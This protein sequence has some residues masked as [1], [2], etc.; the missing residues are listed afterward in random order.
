MSFNSQR[1]YRRAFGIFSL[2]CVFSY[3]LFHFNNYILFDGEISKYAGYYDTLEYIRYAIT[4]LVFFLIPTVSAVILTP[5]TFA[6]KA[7]AV[8]PTALLLSA[9]YVFYNIPYYYMYHIAY[10]YDSIESLLICIP[11]SFILSLIYALYTLGLA[12]LARLIF[13]RRSDTPD[14]AKSCGHFS[15]SSSVGASVFSSVAIH[16]AFSF[17][18]ELIDA[19]SFFIEYADSYRIGELIYIVGRFIFIMLLMLLCQAVCIT[20]HNKI[21]AKRFSNDSVNPNVTKE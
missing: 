1:L 20:V 15:L 4:D 7:Y 2:L 13:Y 11:Y 18:R 17:I 10:G 19:V 21:L 9:S 14:Y 12:Y 6:K 5:L 8:Y 16:F 3:F